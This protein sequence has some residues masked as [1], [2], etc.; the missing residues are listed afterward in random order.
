M[1]ELESRKYM[2]MAIEVMKKS[3]QEPRSD[4]I[5]PK[6]GAVLVM[7]D[8]SFNTAY[9]GELRYG[10]H[11]EF[12]LLERKNR[13]N[14]LTGSILFSTLEP[15][16]PGSRCE[17]KMACAER[18][19]LARIKKVWIGLEDPDPTVDRKGIKYLLDNDVEVYMFDRDLQQIIEKENY[20][21]LAQAKNRAESYERIRPVILT[22]LEKVNNKADYFDLSEKALTFYRDKI[23]FDGK[24]TEDSF[25]KKLYHK[26]LLD[27]KITKFVP[28][29]LGLILFGNDPEDFYPQ[30]SLRG[31]VTYPNEQTEI[32]DFVGPLIFIPG[33]VENWWKKVM[34]LSIDRS[35]SYRKTLT[36]FPYE[37]IR[38]TIINALVHRDYELKGATCHLRIDKHTITVRSP[39]EPVVPITLEQLQSFSAPTLSRNP[40]IFSLF[41]ELGMVERRGLGMETYKSLPRKYNLP[42]PIYSF[43]KPFLELT[44][45]R[46]IKDIPAL[47][48]EK[49]FNQLSDEEKIGVE[50]IF[51]LQQISKIEY[52]E[53]FN[54]NNRKSERHLKH[55]SEIGILSRK[56][57]GP[58][59][60]YMLNRKITY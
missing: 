2:E 53:H 31:T 4:K 51:T 48:D 24:I 15:C 9:R 29:G 36:D 43:T 18:I 6:V 12:T 39:G 57:A 16:A 28:T 54:F 60:I 49:I 40:Q 50:Y 3:V 30:A 14:D 35:S 20:D 33:A 7:P 10:D 56:G 27:K 22:E 55:L 21:F 52:S 23:K 17:P 19:V 25:V 8:G 58:S 5:C 32:K 34:P 47:T 1:K 42:L 38:E 11:A 13:H 59:T 46:T 45:F 37:P 26:G 41:A 44:F